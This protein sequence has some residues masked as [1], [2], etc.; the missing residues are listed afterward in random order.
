MSLSSSRLTITIQHIESHGQSGSRKVH[1][2]DILRSLVSSS[3]PNIPRAQ[4]F[5]RSGD[6]CGIE[7]RA[8]M[9][10]DS[11]GH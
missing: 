6:G 7:R 5:Q 9:L 8:D 1:V 11:V 3:S 2:C 4:N 10:A